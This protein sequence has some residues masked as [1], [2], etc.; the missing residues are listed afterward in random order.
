MTFASNNPQRL[1]HHYTKLNRKSLSL[2][3]YLSIYLTILFFPCSLC[4]PTMPF[5]SLTVSSSSPL[6]SLSL[7][8]PP[9][10]CTLSLPRIMSPPKSFHPKP[11]LV[12]PLSYTSPLLGKTRDKYGWHVLKILSTPR[13]YWSGLEERGGWASYPYPTSGYSRF[14][15]SARQMINDD[16]T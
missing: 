7:S 15:G 5:S 6:L 13:H 11:P 16:L 1:I 4:P 2:S 8:Y 10:F 3:I 14:S 9:L 12:S